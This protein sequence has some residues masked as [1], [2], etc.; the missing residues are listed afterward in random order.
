MRAL[1]VVLALLTLAAC[2]KK[3]PI[4]PPGP[5]DQV[6]YPRQYPSS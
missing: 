6:I 3:G 1:A 4:S 5:P 2:G